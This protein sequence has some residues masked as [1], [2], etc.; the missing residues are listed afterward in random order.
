MSKT[1]RIDDSL[2]EQ[3]KAEAKLEK[4]SIARQIEFWAKVGRTVLANPDLPA[5][6]VAECLESLSE[7]KDNLELY[8]PLTKTLDKNSIP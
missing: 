3:A 6:F 8:V 5:T 4:R 1:I 2:Y 7:S